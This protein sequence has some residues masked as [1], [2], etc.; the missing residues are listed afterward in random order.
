MRDAAG[1]K[2]K[3]TK[4]K[5]LKWKHCEPYEQRNWKQVPGKVGDIVGAIWGVQVQAGEPRM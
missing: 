3:K 2:G 4:N 5:E 1:K